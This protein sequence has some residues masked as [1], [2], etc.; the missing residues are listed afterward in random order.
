MTWIWGGTRFNLVHQLGDLSVSQILLSRRSSETPQSHGGAAE[1]AGQGLSHLMVPAGHPGSCC[2]AGSDPAAREWGLRLCISDEVPGGA[3][4]S[5]PQT[6]LRRALRT[7]HGA[8]QA[9]NQCQHSRWGLGL[10][11]RDPGVGGRVPP[12]PAAASWSR[13]GPRGGPVTIC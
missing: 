2:R 4:A 5:G 12:Q 9:L 10:P 13:W 3:E 7:A 8:C 6:A 1:G 11:S